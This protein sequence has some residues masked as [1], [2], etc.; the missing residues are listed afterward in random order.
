MVWKVSM[1]PILRQLKI[2]L[3]GSHQNTCWLYENQLVGIAGPQKYS[4]PWLVWTP[5]NFWNMGHG[6]RLCTYPRPQAA[7][8]KKIVFFL[9]RAVNQ[10]SFNEIPSPKGFSASRCNVGNWKIRISAIFKILVLFR[11]EDYLIDAKAAESWF[12]KWYQTFIINC[13]I[14]VKI[15]CY[16]D[17]KLTTTKLMIKTLSWF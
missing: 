15:F 12:K 11:V 17:N 7:S 6:R 2:L 8:E 4:T 3:G 1:K 13:Q 14:L 16:F 5:I 9:A 10:D